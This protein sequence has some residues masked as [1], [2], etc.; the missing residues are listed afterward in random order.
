MVLA[1]I[2]RFWK[3]IVIIALITLFVEL[4]ISFYSDNIPADRS[5]IQLF[6][7]SQFLFYLTP[8]IL[9]AIASFLIYKKHEESKLIFLP[10]I[11]I[12][13]T[14]AIIAIFFISDILMIP[15]EIWAIA[16]IEEGSLPLEDASIDFLKFQETSRVSLESVILIGSHCGFALIG[17]FIGKKLSRKLGIK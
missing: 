4:G 17:S 3:E 5:N 14:G 11:A 12:T 13:I 10:V 6:A 7:A 8:L 1:F 2:K 16:V 9:A 15:D